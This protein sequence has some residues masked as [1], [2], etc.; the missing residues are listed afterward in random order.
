MRILFLDID[1]VLNNSAQFTGINNLDD[2]NV[3]QLNRIIAATDCQIVISSDWR[4]SHKKHELEQFLIRQGA[5]VSVA[6]TWPLVIPITLTVLLWKSTL[7]PQSC[8][9]LL[10]LTLDQ[11]A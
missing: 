8:R 2:D 10:W 6:L 1:G 9:T 7:P 4:H 3:A 11:R 5:D